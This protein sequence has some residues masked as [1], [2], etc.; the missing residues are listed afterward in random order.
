MGGWVAGELRN[1]T[2]LQPSSVEVELGNITLYFKQ[3]F[4]LIDNGITK[5]RGVNARF[6]KVYF[7]THI[8]QL[9]YW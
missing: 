1:K 5:G 3:L 7:S 2:K 8:L 9:T 4:T 6:V